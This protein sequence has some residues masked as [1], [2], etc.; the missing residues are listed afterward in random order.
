MNNIN[1]AFIFPGQG[2][3]LV[4]M[5]KDLYYSF[6]DAQEVFEIVDDAINYNLTKLILEGPIEEL[7]NTENTQPALLAACMAIVKIIELKAESSLSNLCLYSAGHSLGEYIA[8]CATGALTISDAAKLLRA[9][10]KAMGE[11]KGD[12]GM[13]ACLNIPLNIAEIIS[14]EVNNIGVCVVANHNSSTQLVL[15]GTNKALELAATKITQAGG[16]AIKLNVSGAFHSP[17]MQPAQDIMADI[18]INTKMNFP[19]KPIIA[20]VAAIPV[21]DPTGI[22]TYLIEQITGRVRWSETMDFFP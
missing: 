13:L 9:R 20:N 10:G 4:G 18:I 8:L 16:R 12:S 5:A 19:A 17:L 15:S 1:R 22:K 2:S 7:T 21:S 11:A 6:S 14:L 3:Q